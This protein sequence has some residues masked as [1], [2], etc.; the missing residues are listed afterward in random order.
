MWNLSRSTCSCLSDDYL[1]FDRYIEFSTK[2]SAR[3]ARGTGGCRVMQIVRGGKLW[4]FC[5]LACNHKSFLAN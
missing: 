3:K 1:V 4:G 5:G 2:C